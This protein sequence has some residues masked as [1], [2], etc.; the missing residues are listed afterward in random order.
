[1]AECDFSPLSSKNAISS[2]G[3]ILLG[4]FLY[5][6]VSRYF[7]TSSNTRNSTLKVNKPTSVQN[8]PDM[9]YLDD[10]FEYDPVTNVLYE[11]SKNSTDPFTQKKPRKAWLV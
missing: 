11:V 3:L 2:C 5:Y 10:N 1:M 9:I 8:V 6:I 7:D 4:F